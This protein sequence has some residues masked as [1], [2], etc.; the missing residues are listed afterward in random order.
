VYVS[1]QAGDR[2]TRKSD[3]TFSTY[4]KSAPS[5]ITVNEKRTFQ[6][7]EGFGATFN[8]AGMICLNSLSAADRNNVFTSLFDSV[9][10]SGFTMM[11]SPIAACDFA[12]AG[13]W[14]SY[15]E[16]ADDTLM[17]HF[18]IER[19]LGANGL[20]TFI[21][22]A[23]HFGKFQIESPMDFAPDWM[24][25]SLKQGEKHIK[26]QYYPALA[27]YY[28]HYLKSYLD[29]GVHIDYLNL[30]NE[31]SNTW[32][33]NVTYTEIADM[34]KNYVAPQLKK[35]RSDV[36]IQFGETADRPEAVK[37]FPVALGDATLQKHINSLAVHG[38]DWNKFSTLTDLHNR[39]PHLPIY[40][41]EVCYASPN[42]LAPGHPTQM[43]VYEFSDGEFWG[44]MIVNDMKNWVCAWIYWNMILDEN[45]GP[46]LVSTVHG[47]PENNKQ[48]PVVIIN[49][50]TK[51]VT[52]TG[53][54]YYLSHFS[55]FVRPG[56]KRID[57]SAI[58]KQ[59]NLVGFQN[60]DNTIVVNVINNGD[61]TNYKINW[62]GKS[63]IQNFPA[64]SITTLKWNALKN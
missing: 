12:S 56:A 42:N 14:Y 25:Y 54:Y 44:N 29:N 52:Y 49:R 24:Y 60:A 41:T 20:I 17:N 3:A 16:T 2:L 19:D 9:K 33:S 62:N 64:H 37:K 1:S 35:D 57:C 53:L 5:V 6:T 28:S 46:W 50:T 27:R 10:G 61:E 63:F 47:D 13:P 15:D 31:A 26:P 58:S 40:M 51:E 59:L 30:F 4:A 22:T 36:K 32:Y 43:P 11:K 48:H 38:Y 34:I 21:K 23:S 7:I 8:E 55:K 45:G 18:T 39:Y